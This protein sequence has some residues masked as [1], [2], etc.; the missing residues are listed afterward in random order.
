MADRPTCIERAF[1]LAKSGKCDSVKSVR[2]QLKAEGYS[3]AGHLSGNAIRRQLMALLATARANPE[4][5][6]FEFTNVLWRRICLTASRQTRV[7][8][9]VC[10][11]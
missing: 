9:C 3:E 8:A 5:A 6:V 1:A 11:G 4:L 10:Y 2:Q 7:P